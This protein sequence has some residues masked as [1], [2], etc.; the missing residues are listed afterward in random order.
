[1]L[2]ELPLALVQNAAV[3]ITAL[4]FGL[5]LTWGIVPA[6]LF[7]VLFSLLFI[8]LGVI[9]GS[10]MNGKNAPAVC[11]AVVQAAA[12]LSGMWFDLDAIGGG[13][14]TFCRVL[15]FANVYD[16]VRY[17]LVG[18]LSHVWLPFLIAFAYTAALV[19]CAVVA[20]R[21]RAMTK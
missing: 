19:I 12:L 2:A 9:F 20:F 10:I 1:M 21:K 7:S 8:A 15:P 17:T 5:P 3:F 6:F 11:S 16:L 14:A 18:D 13:F 4:C